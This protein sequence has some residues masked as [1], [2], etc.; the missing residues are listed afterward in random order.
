MESINLRVARRDP[1]KQTSGWSEYSVELKE[2]TT[3]LDCLD[4]VQRTEDPSL[5][6]RYACRVGMCGSCAMVVNG[7]ERWTCRT[8]VRDLEVSRLTV[9]PLR[10]LPVIRDLVVDFSPLWEKY[11]KVAPYSLPLEKGESRRRRQGVNERRVSIEPN[12]QCISCGACYSSCTFVGTDPLYLGPHA[13]NRVFTLVEDARDSAR[14]ARLAIVDSEHG[15]WKC[16]IQQNCTEVCPMDLSPSAGIQHLKRAILEKRLLN[17]ERRKFAFAALGALAASV[18]GYL[19]MERRRVW[20]TVGSLESIPADDVFQFTHEDQHVFL[21]R[22]ASTTVLALS[23]RCSHWG[24]IVRFDAPSNQFRCPCHL[25]VF[26]SNGDV[27][28]GA[29]VR[30]LESFETRIDGDNIQ[31]RI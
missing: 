29:P 17:P 11:R 19:V 21:R 5:A 26:N 20:V 3:V 13:M 27:L 16:H 7:K 23:Q 24:C 18:I 31:V 15:C 9:E 12:L 8:L 2:K 4:R 14:D 10:H 1:E 25:G 30:P 28:S 6:F 22:T